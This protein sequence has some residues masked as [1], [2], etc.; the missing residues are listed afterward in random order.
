MINKH[1]NTKLVALFVGADDAD[2][3]T[4]WQVTAG[5]NGV[6]VVTS[7]YVTDNGTA[8]DILT[9]AAH[10]GTATQYCIMARHGFRAKIKMTGNPGDTHDFQV[11][12]AGIT[13]SGFSAT[14]VESA[15][16]HTTSG[17]CITDERKFLGAMGTLGS[18]TQASRI[19]TNMDLTGIIA[20]GDRINT[21][22]VVYTVSGTP[23]APAATDSVAAAA[24]HFQVQETVPGT[25]INISAMTT[26]A[27]TF[28]T[29][30]TKENEECSHRGMCD[31]SAGVCECFNGYTMDDCSMQD[32]LFA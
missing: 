17:I 9:T 5:C 28:Y 12:S 10:A 11:D 21:S 23:T 31:Y 4:R 32:A 15:T 30:G 16:G 19:I 29:K 27:A 24:G 3:A 22:G 8:G 26:P 6:G 20:V 18:G 13:T 1:V 14:C 25:A 7:A 2:R